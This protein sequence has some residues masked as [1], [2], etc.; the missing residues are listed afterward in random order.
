MTTIDSPFDW[1]AVATA[2]GEPHAPARPIDAQISQGY[3][4]GQPVP[5]EEFNWL[6]Y[7]IGRSYMPVYDDLFD[8]V[9]GLTDTAGDPVEQSCQVLENDTSTEPG[10]LVTAVDTGIDILAVDVDGQYVFYAEQGATNCFAVLRDLSNTGAP[11]VT[12]NPTFVG[13]NQAIASNGKYVALAYGNFVEVFNRDTGVSI[14]SLNNLSAVHDIA[15]DG[16]NLYFVCDAGGA[17]NEAEAYTLAAGAA[18]WTY[19]HGQHLYS[20]ATDGKRV[21]VSG[22][23]VPAGS[24]ASLRALVAS[25]G[26]DAA[27]EGGTG[28]DTTGVAWDAI[29]AT[30]ITAGRKLTT[31]GRGLWIVYPVAAASEIERRACGDG[32]VTATATAANS[33]TGIAHDHEF[34]YVIINSAIPNEVRA[35]D[36]NALDLVWSYYNPHGAT[37][38]TVCVASDGARVFFGAADVT[39]AAVTIGRLVRGNRPSLWR[40]TN[41]DDNFMPMRQLIIPHE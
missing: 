41:P 9:E 15:I 13:N 4:D 38:L 39:G 7:M 21:Y 2:T 22:V 24:L 35:Y 10:S 11:T 18:V 37:D 12:Y 19:A 28:L 27:N 25:N 5:A 16:E 8:A 34:V 6:A 23:A 30:I 17:G 1:G 31:D 26:F 32:A 29:Q 40:R 33:V 36:R 3:P 14:W 20:V